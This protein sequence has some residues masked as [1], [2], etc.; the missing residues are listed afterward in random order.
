[1]VQKSWKLALGGVFVV[2]LIGAGGAML[3]QAAGGHHT[4][5]VTITVPGALNLS[6]HCGGDETHHSDG[7]SAQVVPDGHLCDVEA[8]LSPAM[9]LR[10]QL[11]I[12]GAASYTCA[13]DGMELDCR[14]DE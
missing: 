3:P 6:L 5:P 9:P 11:E 10:G 1:M 4:G 12:T 7:P 14:A 2:A 13:R 8:P